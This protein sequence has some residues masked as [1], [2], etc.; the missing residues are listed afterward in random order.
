MDEDAIPPIPVCSAPPPPL[1]P[2][3]S[4]TPSC[5]SDGQSRHRRSGR[6]Q[7]IRAR[8]PRKQDYTDI[9]AAQ[10]RSEPN[11]S[12]TKRQREI[13]DM[14]Q[15]SR[16]KL[17][18]AGRTRIH[19]KPSKVGFSISFTAEHQHEL[20]N[21]K[22]P[23]NETDV[24]PLEDEP[25]L[26][27]PDATKPDIDA[28]GDLPG[29]E[30]TSV[31]KG[32]VIG[33]FF[34]SLKSKMASFTEI[35]MTPVKL[36]RA[37]SPS[38]IMDKELEASGA[39]DVGDS[40]QSNKYHSEAQIQ[41][42]HQSL[43]DSAETKS[44]KRLFDGSVCRT[45][46]DFECAISEKDKNVPDA[47]HLVHGSFDSLACVAFEQVGK[48]SGSS[49]PFQPSA[50]VCDSNESNSNVY[51]AVEDRE[52]DLSCV[53][54]LI[55]QDTGNGYEPVKTES[56]DRNRLI[57]LQHDSEEAANA[58]SCSL[59]RQSLSANKSPLKPSLDAE[60][61]ECQQISEMCSV[62]KLVQ[63]KRGL[64]PNSQDTVKRKKL[65]M[66]LDGDVI[67][68]PRTARKRVAVMHCIKG[69]D[70]TI[71]PDSKRRVVST[72]ANPKAKS[73]QNQMV[74]SLD[75]NSSESHNNS[76][77]IKVKPSNS[78]KRLQ[79]KT[80]LTKFDASSDNVLD[81]DV[82]VP[83]AEQLVKKRL[84]VVLVRP[85]MKELQLA[86]KCGNTNKTQLKRKSPK[87]TTLNA[88]MQSTLVSTSPHD[89]LEPMST[90]IN[91]TLSDH[92][93][94]ASTRGASQPSKR[95]KKGLRSAVKF[96]VLAKTEE[97]TKESQSKRG[98]GQIS[99][100]SVFFE[101]TPFEAHPELLQSK[102]QLPL[103][104]SGELNKEDKLVT[105][106]KRMSSAS[107]AV[108]EISNC[109]PR[110]S[111]RHVNTRQ[112][113]SDNQR[114]CKVLHSRICKTEEGSRS[115]T[116]EDADLTATRL[117]SSENNFSRRLL[118]SYSCPDVL[119][120][121]L[122]D[123]PWI[124]SP[125]SP[126][127]KTHTSHHYHRQHG[128]FSSHAQRSPRRARRHTVCSVEVEREI[129]PLCLR[130]EVYPSRRSAS[131]DSVTHHLSPAHAH[132]PCSSLTA[133]A[134]CF[135]SSPLAFLSKKSDCRGTTAHTSTS[136][137]VPSP[138][139]SSFSCSTTWHSPGFALGSNSAVLDSSS[140]ENS[141]PY[142]TERRQRS[143][144]DDDGEDTSSSSQE[145]EDAGMREEKALSVFEIRVAKKHEEQKKVSSIRIRK[146]LPKP[147]T[148]LTPMG[149]PKPI[150][151]KK[152]EF[153]L[154]EIYTNKNFNKAPESRLETIFEVPLNR[155]N[156]SESWF[157]QRRVK[158][159]LEFLEVGEVRKPKKP[160][161][162]VGKAATSSS[163]PRRGGFPKDEPSLS[164][165]DVDSLLCSKLDQLNLWLIH[166][167]NDD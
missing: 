76:K 72:R 99:V 63:A 3:S 89:R 111:I 33:P 107:T 7:E 32:W 41:T 163:R 55:R 44:A 71:K 116:V 4:I 104:C 137:H 11:P 166:D 54:P 8:T 16:S 45:E 153:S 95:L 162:G 70:E 125:H 52:G 20:K 109:S 22:S 134:S 91:S 14:V 53:K 165:Q 123:S 21:S 141:T 110:P 51:T 49:V 43:I 159:F 13:S 143:E 119:I 68:G 30:D 114:R 93:E 117:R 64:K 127:H 65:N 160:L 59:V 18:R 112:R 12:P 38:L 152:K 167:Q 1:L 28:C 60:Q 29:S 57:K 115:I 81:V 149:L 154:E 158:R 67:K 108:S 78:C 80:V 156:G 131:Y 73:E 79:T 155:K 92:R 128:H 122:D 35:V 121:H 147:Q 5:V 145:S 15:A 25:T 164:I 37:N 85:E 102:T 6:I 136:S 19:K 103:L 27:N 66:E 23:D 113:R 161:V 86:T 150:R 139:P 58:E 106:K 40:E 97:K 151:V 120:L 126:N 61:M 130:K 101:M 96:T 42:S 9:Q 132:S 129:A 157:G 94:D 144:E 138:T 50:K 47:V 69:E 88:G 39:G 56:E 135:L 2:L 100:G 31:S 46:R 36:F 87:H 10:K 62:S 84:C 26:E 34:Q 48:R 74:C 90:D 140:S 98:R 148:N 82:P 142:E 118:R 17:Q 75:K 133:L 77:C 24:F 105:E 124:S 146:T 83:A